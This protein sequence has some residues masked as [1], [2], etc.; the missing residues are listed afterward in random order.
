MGQESMT[1]TVL[2]VN[3]PHRVLRKSLLFCT[4]ESSHKGWKAIEA[5]DSADSCCH[6]YAG[7]WKPGFPLS[8]LQVKCQKQFFSVNNP[9][10]AKLQC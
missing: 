6:H 5:Q 1:D 7:L 2:S 9:V 4:R 10:E 8:R 3:F